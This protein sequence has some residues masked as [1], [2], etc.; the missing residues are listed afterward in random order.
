MR[1]AIGRRGR[2][3]I[4][5]ITIT[6]AACGGTMA[7]A[8]APAAA[9]GGDPQGLGRWAPF[10]HGRTMPGPWGG[11]WREGPPPAPTLNGDWAPFNRCPVDNPTML[12][13]DGEK[14]IVL[15]VTASSPSGAIKIGNLALP[16]GEGNTQFGLVGENAE[17][18]TTYKV[19]SPWG[20]VISMAPVELPDGLAALVCPDASP[21]LRWICSGHP[22]G[23]HG[24]GS[25]RT[26]ITATVQPAGEPSNFDLDGAVTTGIP[27][28]SIPV[29]IQLQNDVLGPDCYIGSDSE[30]I[31]LQLET[32]VPYTSSAFESFEADGNTATEGGPLIRIALLGGTDGDESFAVPGVSGCGF[33][34]GLDGVID[35][36]AALPSPAGENAVVMNETSTYLTGL[37]SP[38]EVAP[39]D[40]KDLSQ[41]WH[42]AIQPAPHGY[43]HH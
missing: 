6:A 38:G 26:N 34:G 11:G 9:R 33:R 41:D 3:A 43:G 1:N 36:N 14:S 5:A 10:G 13:A 17:S 29:K 21:A 35:H 28:L 18:E 2:A 40:G 8:A 37:S 22:S 12:A 7:V 20:G 16:T 25:G 39:N 19:V 15:C 30:P 32:L 4:V 27:I 24:S 42:S 23:P 31:V